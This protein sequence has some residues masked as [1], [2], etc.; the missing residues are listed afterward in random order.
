MPDQPAVIALYETHERA[1]A[2]VRQLQ[3]AGVDLAGVSIIGGGG[4]QRAVPV[5]LGEA[6]AAF[7]RHELGAAGRSRSGLTFSVERLP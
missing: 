7:V 5:A 2:A 1:D 4:A 3:Q 6:F